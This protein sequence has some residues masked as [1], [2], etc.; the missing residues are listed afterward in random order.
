MYDGS[1]FFIQPFDLLSVDDSTGKFLKKK[2]KTRGLVQVK[3]GDDPNEAK[4]V[5]MRSALTR[6]EKYVAR[7]NHINDLQREKK[8][9]PLEKDQMMRDAEEWIP[10]LKKA[11]AKIGAVVGDK[12]KEARDRQVD[13][14]MAKTTALPKAEELSLPDLRQACRERNID[15][16]PSWRRSNYIKALR[17]PVKEQP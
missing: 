8:F 12:E 17:A 3:F 10:R 2:C 1:V 16:K 14:L 13:E 4:L 5:A 15:F 9:P 7:F 11:I 6:Y